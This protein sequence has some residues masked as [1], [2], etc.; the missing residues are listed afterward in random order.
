MY[1]TDEMKYDVFSVTIIPYSY[2][3]LHKYMYFLQKLVI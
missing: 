2:Y 1:F 3:L